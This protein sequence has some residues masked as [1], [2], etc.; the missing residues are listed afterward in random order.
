[1]LLQKALEISQIS[2]WIFDSGFHASISKWFSL[3]ANKSHIKVKKMSKKFQALF[4]FSIF[5]ILFLLK[6]K[7]NLN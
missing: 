4:F 5:F 7:I 1:M 3:R 6:K 2:R